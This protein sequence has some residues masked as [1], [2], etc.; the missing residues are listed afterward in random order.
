MAKEHIGW[1]K[2]ANVPTNGG[3]SMMRYQVITW[4]RDEGH[5]ERRE[6]STLAQ[7]RAAGCPRI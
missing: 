1:E 5:N 2:D 7:A 3:H 4:T 6:F